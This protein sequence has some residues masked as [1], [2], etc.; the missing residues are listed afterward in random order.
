MKKILYVLII[1]CALCIVFCVNASAEGQSAGAAE[2]NESEIG[3]LTA[4]TASEN[5]ADSSHNYIV[6]GSGD[7]CVLSEYIN[8]VP[9]RLASGGLSDIMNMV[10]GGTVTFDGVSSDQGFTLGAGS[11]TFLGELSIGGQLTVREGARLELSELLFTSSFDG[12][13]IRIK[14]GAVSVV[15]ASINAKNTAVLLDYSL[16]SELSLSS[17]VIRSEF[18]EYAVR[19]ELGSAR[20]IGGSVYAPRG[21][22]LFCDCSVSLGEASLEYSEYAIVSERP[23]TLLSANHANGLKLCYLGPLEDGTLT[24]LVYRATAESIS[25]IKVYDSHG[26]E[27]PL[28]YFEEYQGRD[29]QD[30]LG[31]YLPFTVRYFL[32]GELIK[33]EGRLQGELLSQ[34]DAPEISG[35]KFCGWNYNGLS[36]SDGFTV[37]ESADLFG[38]YALL[39][40]SITAAGLTFIYDGKEHFA[41]VEAHHPQDKNGGAYSYKWYKGDTLVST[42]EC[43]IIKDRSDSGTYRCEVTFYHKTK[44]V[45]AWAEGIEISVERCMLKLPCANSAVYNGK[46]QTSSLSSCA[47]YTVDEIPHTEAGQ[48]FVTLTLV[49]KD[50]YVFENGIEKAEIPFVILS[51]E[52]EWQTYPKVGSVYCGQKLK[53]EALARWGTPVYM[54]SDKI[55]GEYTEKVPTEA[56]KY[57]FKAVVGENIS[58]S[59]LSSEPCEFEILAERAIGIE[60]VSPPSKTDYFAF[61]YFS[62]SGLAAKVTYNSG[63]SEEI[64]ADRL[65]VSYQS[66]DSF[67]FGDNGVII[68]YLG[69]KMSIGVNVSPAEYDLFGL[70]FSNTVLTYNGEYRTAKTELPE[71]I[72]L[73]GYGLKYKISGGGRD[74]GVYTVTLSFETDSIN[75]RLPGAKTATLEILPLEVMIIWGEESFIYDGTAKVPGG[76]YIDAKGIERPVSSSGAVIDAGDGYTAYAIPTDKNYSFINPER[77]FS[78]KRAI[79]DTSKAYWVGGGIYCGEQMSVSLLGLPKGLTVIGYTDGSAT[80]AGKYTARAILSYDEKNYEPPNIAPYEWEILKAEYDMSAVVI[81]STK[82]VYDGLMHYPIVL[83]EMPKGIDGSS[84]KYSFSCGAVNVADGEISV[85]VIFYTDSKNYAPPKT[86]YA[87]VVIEPRGVMVSWSESRFV[88]SS[89]PLCPSAVSEKCP[90]LVSGEAQ[91]A[92]E[93]TAKAQSADPNYT[94]INSEYSFVIEKAENEWTLLPGIEDIYESG[95][96]SPYGKAKAGE[97]EFLFYRDKECK[98]PCDPPASA[99]IYYLVAYVPEGKNHLALASSPIEFEIFRVELIGIEARLTTSELIA[100]ERLG[101][102]DIILTLIYNDGTRKDADFAPRVIYEGGEHLL[103]SDSFVTVEYDGFEER[104]SITVEKAKFDMS[105]ARWENTSAVYDGK[106][107]APSLVGLPSGI[108]VKGYDIDGAI[109]AGEYTFK[110]IFEYD[111]DNYEP[112]E[113]ISCELI[114]RK[115]TVDIPKPEIFKYN[116]KAHKFLDTALYEIERQEI[117]N[118]GEYTLKASLLDRDNYEFFGGGSECQI[119]VT[120]EPIELSISIP[121]VE[122][123]LFDSF[124]MPAFSLIEGEIISGERLSYSAFIENGKITLRSNDPNYKITAFGGEVIKY[125]YPSNEDTAR[126][127]IIAV[128]LVLLVLMLVLLFLGRDR[129]RRALRSAIPPFTREKRKAAHDASDKIIITPPAKN[130]GT[131]CQSG[132]NFFQDDGTKSRSED[133]LVQNDGTICQNGDIL[134]QDDGTKSQNEDNIVQNENTPPKTDDVKDQNDAPATNRE[135]KSSQAPEREKSAEQAP[136]K[137]EVSNHSYDQNETTPENELG[138]NIDKADRL[139]TDSLAKDLIRREREALITYGGGQGIINVDTLSRSFKSGERVDVNILKEKRLVPYDTAYLKVLARGVID[140]PLRVY[141]NE[142]SLS[143][144]K[145]IALTGGE[146]IKVNTVIRKSGGKK[147]D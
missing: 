16:S 23:I 22:A 130:D 147:R 15:G 45:S 100:M 12:S 120:V 87:T 125:G 39:A 37:T 44:S 59:G 41:A 49:D 24:E 143:A 69:A 140:K 43:I 34:T 112:P 40:P 72:G 13:A 21:S 93:Y 3:E 53:I 101:E 5:T 1:V 50:N 71:I 88:Y 67:R 54:F 137:A 52:N 131:I 60:L 30:F 122:L 8:G 32:G 19:V 126:I 123:Y 77:E 20:L 144:V 113:V 141:A 6:S 138:V 58:Y 94:V 76:Y 36:V 136:E 92:G 121:Q 133:I 35:Y 46:A 84:P 2:L 11:Y 82:A 18:G 47:L 103:C 64:G 110:A 142:F 81:E 90:I 105:G 29:E 119:S 28:T 57:Y 75:Y 124:S 80:E 129:I 74:A 95:I 26:K 115:Q 99:G 98:I 4:D 66:G 42:A 25:K 27:Y 70:V 17:G 79:Y 97:A 9:T 62:A 48:Y 117:I 128:A 89:K 63:R 61:E 86:A 114:I 65:A 135:L 102:G 107:H 51:A 146:V 127:V 106:P 91:N 109:R 55:D 145:M 68:S 38:E 139:I 118:A 96:I 134:F 10:R 104:I 132:D 108:T 73:D 7:S 31:V 14:G 56:G 83:G 33:T 116:G 85:A 78:V 111:E